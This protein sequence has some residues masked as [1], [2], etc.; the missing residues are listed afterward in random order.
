[1]INTLCLRVSVILLPLNYFQ[2]VY[3]L[4]LGGYNFFSFYFLDE[5]SLSLERSRV[6]ARKWGI[7]YVT[8]HV[9]INRMRKNIIVVLLLLIGISQVKSQDVMNFCLSWIKSLGLHPIEYFLDIL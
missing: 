5:W 1:M 4:D 9:G 8:N 7:K 2:W 3:L 6:V